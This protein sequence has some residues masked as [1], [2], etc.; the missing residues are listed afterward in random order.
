[1]KAQLIQLHHK[2]ALMKRGV[3][4]SVND[5][6]MTVCDLEHTRHR[7]PV[8]AILMNDKGLWH[9]KNNDSESKVIV[10]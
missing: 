1:M 3:I 4:E 6:L 9:N 5:I 2:Y 7:S 10:H 8:N